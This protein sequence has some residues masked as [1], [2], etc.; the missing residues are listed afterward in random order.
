V[1]ILGGGSSIGE[2]LETLDLCGLSAAHSALESSLYLEPR[3][4]SKYP[5]DIIYIITYDGAHS[6]STRLR[7][8]RVT[9]ATKSIC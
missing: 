2:W 4:G 5:S 9:T 1:A 6:Y 7:C 3:V 8:K